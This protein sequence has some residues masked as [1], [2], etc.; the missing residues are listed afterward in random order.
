MNIDEFEAWDIKPFEGCEIQC[1]ECKKWTNHKDW[2]LV[3]EICETCGEHDAIQ[4]PICEESFGHVYDTKFRVR[5]PVKLV[6]VFR[7]KYEQKNFARFLVLATIYFQ[8]P[9]WE[10]GVYAASKEYVEDEMERIGIPDGWKAYSTYESLKEWFIKNCRP[11][12][13]KE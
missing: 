4:C 12:N 6:A 10:E 9:E 13:E 2:N 8:D 1:P 7:S 5:D 11:S 3:S